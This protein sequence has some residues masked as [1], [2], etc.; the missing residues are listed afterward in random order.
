[1]F[2]FLKKAKDNGEPALWSS[3]KLLINI[4]DENDNSP[5]CGESIFLASLTENVNQSNLLQIKATDHDS[6]QN[7]V[8]QYFLMTTLNDAN[9][10]VIDQFSGWI[11]LKEPLDYEKKS[12]YELNIEVRDSGRKSV[13]KTRCAARVNVI[14]QNDNP[15][16]I[17]IIEYLDESQTSGH[18]S[19]NTMSSNA[20]NN[21]EFN[22]IKVYENNRPNLMLALVKV[23]D[24][25]ELSNYKFSISPVVYG[26]H[27]TSIFKIRMR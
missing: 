23:F 11:S 17:K 13:M 16:K 9:L 15:A 18:Y 2:I 20:E 5:I 10:F 6:G 14:D 1:M 12:F 22:E 8:L 21:V 19:F 27:N 26:K 24:S 25:D 4:Q 7:S 3:K